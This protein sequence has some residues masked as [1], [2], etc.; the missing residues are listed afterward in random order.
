M[1]VD[2]FLISSS[3]IGKSSLETIDIRLNRVPRFISHWFITISFSTCLYKRESFSFVRN[4]SD[5]VH[6]LFDTKPK[7]PFN[8][9]YFLSTLALTALVSSCVTALGINCRGSS[10][11]VSFSC[12]D[13]N[14]AEHLYE[15][16][17]TH[18]KDDQWYNDGEQLACVNGRDSWS[19]WGICAF[20]QGTNGLSGKDLKTLA[21]RIV[22]HGCLGC[23]SVPVYFDKNENDVALH[24]M[25]TFNYVKKK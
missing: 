11:C 1:Y 19:H 22:D 2:I 23:G 6:R 7:T 5:I 16:M 8:M 21:L 14:V 4:I 13:E 18:L 12:S 15:K 3:M 20:L 17:F 10:E 25:L 24:G 9:R